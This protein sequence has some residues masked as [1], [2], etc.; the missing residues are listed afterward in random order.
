MIWMIRLK[1]A[2]ESVLTIRKFKCLCSVSMS[3]QP[4]AL[5]PFIVFMENSNGRFG[6]GK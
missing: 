5:E 2:I 1:A 6:A 4:F 3:R